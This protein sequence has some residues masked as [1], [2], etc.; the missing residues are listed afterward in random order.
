MVTVDAPQLGNREADAR[1]AFHLPDGLTLGNAKYVATNPHLA[2]HAAERSTAPPAQRAAEALP[3]PGEG[4]V[5]APGGTAALR[6]GSDAREPA[7]GAGGGSAA[8]TDERSQLAALFTA[9]IDDALTWDLIPFLRSVTK[10]PI[11]IK[12]RYICRHIR[13]SAVAMRAAE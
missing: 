3:Q 9:D 2:G 13:F 6:V 4:F 5:A 8:A 10:L 12:V 11:L 7:G 1:N